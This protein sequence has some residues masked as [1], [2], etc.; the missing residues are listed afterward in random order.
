MAL[1][2][3]K[4]SFGTQLH[5]VWIYKKKKKKAVVAQSINIEEGF[6]NIKT[7][8]YYH[9]WATIFRFLSCFSLAYFF[10]LLALSL[11]LAEKVHNN[12]CIWTV[13]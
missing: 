8:E 13:P 5:P 1:G 4:L 9:L 11:V 6:V 10:P 2:E 12:E 3:Q 7:S